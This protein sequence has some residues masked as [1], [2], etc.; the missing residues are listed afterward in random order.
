MGRE[1]S[2]PLPLPRPARLPDGAGDL[3]GLADE[4]VV[5]PTDLDVLDRVRA[6]V[7][8]Q[9][10][11]DGRGADGDGSGEVSGKHSRDSMD[12]GIDVDPTLR[13]VAESSL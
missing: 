12:G 11:R 8:L 9:H 3:E 13:R 4:D 10:A 7:E 6:V 1:G 2:D 5:R